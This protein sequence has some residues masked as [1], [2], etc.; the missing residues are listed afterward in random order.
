MIFLIQYNATLQ[1]LLSYFLT[2][3]ENQQKAIGHFYL[4]I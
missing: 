3:L 1:P 4:Y 2:N